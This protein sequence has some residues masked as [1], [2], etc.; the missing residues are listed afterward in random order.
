MRILQSP[1]S[2]CPSRYLLL[3]HWMKSNQF[4]VW[5]AHMNGA[6]NGTIFWPRPLGPWE[7]AKRSNFVKCK[8][9]GQFQ[10]FL[11]QTLRVFSQLKDI[12]H[13]RRDFHSV[14]WVRPQGWDLRRYRGVGR[15]K[16]FFPEFGVW[17]TWMAHETAQFVKSPPPR[18]LWRGQK[19]LNFNY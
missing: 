4:G 3:N 1:P 15:Q 17:V 13:I 12:K 8:L 16:L 10:R 14:A 5:V 9:Q 2:V 7:W 18:A 19:T 6:R 11:N